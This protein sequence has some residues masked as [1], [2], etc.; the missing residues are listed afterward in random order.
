MRA[1]EELFWTSSSSSCA[2]TQERE[3]ERE[4]ER[5]RSALFFPSLLVIVCVA[6]VKNMFI[7]ERISP[8][9]EQRLSPYVFLSIRYFS[10]GLGRIVCVCARECRHANEQRTNH[11]YYRYWT[12]SKEKNEIST[13]RTEAEK[14]TGEKGSSIVSSF[15][16]F[17]YLIS[18]HVCASNVGSPREQR[19]REKMIITR[20][21][22]RKATRTKRLAVFVLIH[23]SYSRTVP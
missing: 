19:E 14:H 16:I 20:S 9:H 13:A 21:Y 22:L 4:N 18:L 6:W 15:S 2:P 17:L 1:R 5:A 10:E 7:D 12:N 11:R 8:F 23:S 3:R